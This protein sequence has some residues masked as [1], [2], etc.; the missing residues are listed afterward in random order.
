MDDNKLKGK[1]VIPANKN[2]WPHEIRVAKAL[3]LAG[4]S[5]EFIPEGIIGTADIYLDGVAYEIKPPKTNNTNTIEHRIKEAINNQS[6]N[7]IIDSSRIKNMPDR[8]LQNWLVD[9]CR[10]QPQIRQMLLV[11]KKTQI[12]DIKALV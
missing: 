7:I 10:K 11:N 4:H 12:V 8:T 9:R 5:V 6:R 2:P 1:V 3:A